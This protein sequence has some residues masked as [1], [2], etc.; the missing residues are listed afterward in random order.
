MYIETYINYIFQCNQS[1]THTISVP[2]AT[3][4]RSISPVD[5]WQRQYSSFMIGAC[6]PFPEPGGPTK[7]VRCCV[8]FASH[9]FLLVSSR[10]SS[11]VGMCPSSS[12]RVDYDTYVIMYARGWKKTARWRRKERKLMKWRMCNI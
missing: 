4:S 7:I 2:A 1:Q 3:A 11:F 10:S 9:R 6:V 5:K 12:N 8:F